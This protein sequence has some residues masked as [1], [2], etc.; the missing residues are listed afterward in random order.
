MPFSSQLK[1]NNRY[2]AIL[3]LLSSVLL[4]NCKKA[5]LQPASASLIIANAIS[6]VTLLPDLTNGEQP[7][8]KYSK[9]IQYSLIYPQNNY[10]SAYSG[11]QRLKLYRQPDTTS[12]DKP[13]FDLALDLPVG[14]ISTLF[15]AGTKEAPDTVFSREQLPEFVGNDSLVALRFI[16]LSPG[17]VPISVNRKGFENGE[18]INGLD[19]KQVSGFRTYPIRFDS[20][21]I[22]EFRNAVTGELICTWDFIGIYERS[23]FLNRPFTIVFSGLPGGTGVNANK[24]FFVPHTA[25]I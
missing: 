5:S 17:Q 2:A 14:S 20:K 13:L 22:F 18:I 23:R 12:K 21:Y 10:F 25:W 3:L 24:A 16:H 11:M 19:Y 7:L 15:L 8:F 6:G 9:P 4:M 1:Y